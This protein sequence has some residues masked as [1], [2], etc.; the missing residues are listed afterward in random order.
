MVDGD[1]TMTEPFLERIQRGPFT[2]ADGAIGTQLMA[3]GLE[4]GKV[5]ESLNLTDPDK[6]TALALEYMAAGAE[7]LTTNTFGGNRISLERHGL[8]GDAEAINRA[9]VLAV[10]GLGAYV[11]GSMGPTGLLL[12]PYGPAT[13]GEVLD[14]FERQA[15]ALLD[16]GA[17]V[18]CVETIMDVREAVLAVRAV[19]TLGA[20]VPTVASM[21]FNR[22]PLGYFTMMGNSVE[23]VA[24]ELE[25]AGADVV[26]TNCGTGVEDAVAIL[27]EFRRHTGLP[28]IIQ[29]NAGVPS[30]EDGEASYPEGPSLTATYLCAMTRAA[31][32]GGCCGTGPAHTAALWKGRRA[33]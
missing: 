14:A 3:R 6:L 23:R 33:A 27:E 18:L 10:A 2:I 19:R 30:L 12:R 8:A 1:W 29:P 15:A 9:S 25:D 22:T 16:A 5:P 13:E 32:V 31:V 7:I 26:G 21:T 28:L 17:D 20:G 4:A 11:S 24:M